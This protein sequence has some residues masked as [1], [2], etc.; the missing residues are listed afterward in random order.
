MATV[1]VALGGTGVVAS[2]QSMTAPPAAERTHPRV[3]P[4][5]G[6]RHT[7]FAVAF[8]LRHDAGVSGIAQNDYRVEVVPPAAARRRAA[9][10]PPQPATVDA[11]AAGSRHRTPLRAPAGGWCAGL[12]AV[13]VYYQS[14]PYCPPPQEGTQP[15]PCPLFATR[16]QPTG[17]AHFR[18]VP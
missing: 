13:T 6:H 16:D 3:G 12:Y 8:T 1:L 2:A 7:G 9:C 11:G 14:G 18:V 17:T 10:A 5:R 4:S 15:R